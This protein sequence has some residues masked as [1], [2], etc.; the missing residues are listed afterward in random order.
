MAGYGDHVLVTG[1]MVMSGERSGAGS[2]RAV[3]RVLQAAH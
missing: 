3:S 1:N 2:R